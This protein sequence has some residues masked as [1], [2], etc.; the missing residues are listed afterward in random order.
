MSEKLITPVDEP[1]KILKRAV[2]E[3]NAVT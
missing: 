3:S 1:D 2:N